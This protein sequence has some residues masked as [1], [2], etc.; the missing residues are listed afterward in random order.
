MRSTVSHAPRRLLASLMPAP[1]LGW[2]PFFFFTNIPVA[3]SPPW[4]RI[5][6]PLRGYKKTWPLGKMS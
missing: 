4:S 1:I 6:K 2:P 5:Q 3:G